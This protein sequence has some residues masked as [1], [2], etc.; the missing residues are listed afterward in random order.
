MLI[1][2]KWLS[3]FVKLPASISDTEL[4]SRL[5]LSTVEVE[6]TIDQAVGLEHIVVGEITS[7]CAHPNAD[8]LRVCR[9]DVGDGVLQIVCGGTN[10]VSGMKVA[11][12]LPGALVRWH[13]EGELV[14]MKK[15]KLRGEDSEGMMCSSNEIGLW[16]TEGEHEIRDLGDVD[17]KPGTPLARALGLDDVLFDIEHKSL[18]NRPDLMGHYGMAREMAAL[19]KSKFVSYEPKKISAGRGIDLQVKIED[20]EACHRYMAVAMEDVIVGESPAWMKRR[21]ESCG[22]RSI[23]TVV[24][25]TNYVMLE[26]GQPMHAFDADVLGHQIVVRRAR[27]KENITALDA[28][29]YQLDPEILL[30]TNGE[31]AVAIAGVKGGE[32]SG[33]SG[34]T[35]RIVL[36]SANFDPVSVRKTT[37]RL[38]LRSESSS[39]FEKSLDAELCDL[40]LRRA[41]AL[42]VQLCPGA[43]VVSN[44]VDVYPKPHTST[45]ILLPSE[46]VNARLGTTIPVGD[47]VGILER[48]GFRVQKKKHSFAVTIPSWRATK[49]VSTAEDLL[50]E[51]IRVWGYDK[52]ESLLPVFSITPPSYDPVRYLAGCLRNTLSVGLG[53]LEIYRY[54]F[55]APGILKTLGFHVEDHLKLANPL[56]QD[57]PYLCQSLVPNL[58][59]SVVL[60]HRAFPVVR[61]FEIARVFL[62]SM[63]G[64]EDGQGGTLP[65]QPYHIG[66]AY[67]AQGDESPL[68]ELRRIVEG[69]LSQAGFKSEC[70]QM[71]QPSEWMHPSRAAEIFVDGKK[72]GILAEVTSQVCEQLGI[73]RRVAIAEVNLSML[74]AIERREPTFTAIPAFPDAKRDLAFMITERTSAADIE[75]A[76]RVA[77]KLLMDYDLFDVYR[78]KGVEEGQKSM[79]VHLTFRSPDK[80]LQAKE[81]DE[82]MDRIRHVLEKTFG[83]IMRS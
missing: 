19:T 52:I 13:G 65:A 60:N 78:G 72:H 32:G 53:A 37:M 57:Q 1:S 66:F 6:K 48:L 68:V 10:V 35:T 67:S 24:D 58:L 4:A 71:Q 73:D 64:D 28:K 61:V 26:L 12:A 5:T 16:P 82:Q 11:V 55:V 29:T 39:R 25:V 38:A 79:A 46:F 40:A 83:A 8:A 75:K 77:S 22:V 70:A 41:V 44:V 7:V 31:R 21:L 49:D 63:R 27:A 56:A 2:K 23:N 45:T 43:H 81:V 14:K 36:E 20:K 62:G 50:E 15:T 42:M 33:V 54:A 80:T 47:M 51:I 3:E 34:K 18:T 9:V 76:V 74:A 30:I 17:A 59:D 69:A